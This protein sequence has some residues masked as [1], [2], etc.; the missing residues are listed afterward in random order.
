MDTNGDG[1]LTIDEL[2]KGYFE[3]MGEMALF[4]GADVAEIL[5]QVDFNDNGVIDYSEFITAASS[6][7]EMLSSKHL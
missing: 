5:T 7:S 2:Q 3:Y 6:I 4:S 1:V